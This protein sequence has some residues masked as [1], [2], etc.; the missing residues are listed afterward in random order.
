M[1]SGI[2]RLVG[3]IEGQVHL[4]TGGESLH[5]AGVGV[6][7]VGDQRGHAVREQVQLR[8][9]LVHPVQLADQGR[10]EDGNRR[11]RGLGN[12]CPESRDWYVARRARPVPARWWRRWCPSVTLVAEAGLVTTGLSGPPTPVGAS[13]IWK[14]MPRSS[15]PPLA[16]STSVSAIWK[17]KRS[18]STS[19]LFSMASARASACER[20]RLPARIRSCTRGGV[21]EVGRTGPPVGDTRQMSAGR[22]AAASDRGRE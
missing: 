3:V 13:A 9:G 22:V 21:L 1:F 11:A 6:E 16:R 15:P 17:L 7:A 12:R 20:Y 14:G 18:S 4:R 5:Q 8:R 10:I 19:R 2:Q